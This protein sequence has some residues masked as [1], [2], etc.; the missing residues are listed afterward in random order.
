MASGELLDVGATLAAPSFRALPE[1]RPTSPAS[2]PSRNS[3][4]K[5]VSS[6]LS[7][8][9]RQYETVSKLGIQA[10]NNADL[11]GTGLALPSREGAASSAPTARI[12]PRFNLRQFRMPI[13][14]KI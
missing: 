7:R 10:G 13:P 1:Q 11:V 2:F 6:L 14:P 5:T 8:N 4:F 9:D 12:S 3:D